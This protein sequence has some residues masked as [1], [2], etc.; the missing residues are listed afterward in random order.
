MQ[1]WVA[2]F[3]FGG[4]LLLFPINTLP[5]IGTLNIREVPQNLLDGLLCF[6]GHGP[7]CE[8]A[9]YPVVGYTIANLAFN[10]IALYVMKDLSSTVM[11][12]QNA[13]RLP[14]VTI[15]FHLS[16]V[17]GQSVKWDNPGYTFSGLAI[18]LLGLA[19]YMISTLRAKREERKKAETERITSLNAPQLFSR[20]SNI[21]PRAGTQ[22]TEL[23]EQPLAPAVVND[24][25]YESP[26]LVIIAW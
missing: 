9:F 19:C 11:Y 7:N 16:F 13:V 14:L 21:E 25:Q 15:V 6:A 8:W 20:G 17:M 24:K 3:Q 4:S 10:I 23:G 1:A 12:I 22:G 18:I 5:V 2:V 26:E